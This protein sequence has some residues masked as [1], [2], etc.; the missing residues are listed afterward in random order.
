MSLPPLLQ[1]QKNPLENDHQAYLLSSPSSLLPLCCGLPDS[2][3]LLVPV[4]ST[5]MLHAAMREVKKP[6]FLQF[7][8][9]VMYFP[10]QQ[11]ERRICTMHTRQKR[12]LA[13]AH[14]LLGVGT[15]HW[16]ACATIEKLDLRP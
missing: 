5:S 4:M 11:T 15:V 6:S 7:T 16:L 10:G 9:S 2:K 8:E 14:E 3:E 1:E 12:K 13:V